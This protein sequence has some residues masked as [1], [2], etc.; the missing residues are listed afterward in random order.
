MAELRTLS[1]HFLSSAAPPD[2]LGSPP[3][4][5]KR[6]VLPALTC[7]KYRGTS[8]YLDS[9]VA[10]IDAPRLRDIDI[11]LLCRPTMDASQ[12]GQFLNRI[13]MQKSHCRAEILSP[14]RTIAIS[15][16]QP[17]APARLELRVSCNNLARGLS[18]MARICKSLSAFL[19]GV[20]LLH[21]GATQPPSG[22]DDDHLKE[23][24]GLIHPFRG[25]KWA[26]LSGNQPTDI[27]LALG[28]RQHEAVLPALH[29][30]YVREP[31]PRYAPLQEAVLSF[32]HSSRLSGQTVCVEYERARV[33]ELLRT[34]PFSQQVTNEIL[35]DDVL[36]NIFRL[37]LHSSPQFWPTLTHIS[38]RWR[39]LVFTSP[40]GLDLRLYCTYGTPVSKP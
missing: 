16:N 29:K 11:T 38:Q 20:E 24:L 2:L 12:L 19:L 31:E 33:D 40:L 36:L 1:L 35:P 28:L 10:G 13:E 4:S 21:I 27:I 15:F 9:V 34:G 22:Q 23:W 6:V 17:E 14:Q 25:T 32:I 18:Y 39:H 30:L 26:H 5:G 37:Y 3:L 7:L 8:K